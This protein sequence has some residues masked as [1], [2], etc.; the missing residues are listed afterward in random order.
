[1]KVT[2]LKHLW[3]I[4]I[5]N[6]MVIMINPS[7]SSRHT[8][9]DRVTITASNNCTRFGQFTHPIEGDMI[10]D[11]VNFIPLAGLIH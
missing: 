5:S 9:R 11:T 8:H 4:M 7:H 2:R 1:M 3:S 6:L 10:S